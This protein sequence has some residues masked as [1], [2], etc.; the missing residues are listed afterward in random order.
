M[1]NNDNIIKLLN[2]KNYDQ[3]IKECETIIYHYL[4]KTNFWTIFP[5]DR[6]D[7]TQ[8]GRMAIYKCC[9]TFDNRNKFTTYIHTAIRNAI[10]NYVKKM[11]MF[12][13]ANMVEVDLDIIPSETDT[14]DKYDMVMGDL[15]NHKNSDILRMYFV[16]NYTQQDI[17]DKMNLS[18]QWVGSLV[19]NFKK[20]ME[21]K[22]GIVV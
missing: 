6:D 18:Q 8:E 22:Y 21:V 20:E 1:I 4:H 9:M 12:D 5:N 14:S 7:M 19:N 10:Y 11:R 2:D 16:E 13:Y 15:T 17:A 3:V